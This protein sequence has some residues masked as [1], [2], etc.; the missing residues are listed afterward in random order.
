MTVLI[1]GNRGQLGWALERRASKAGISTCCVDLP[2]LDLTRAK[3]VQQMV[4]RE[5][6]SAVVN[7]AAYTAVDKAETDLE[8][9][10][11][12]NRD[13]VAHLA[14]ACRDEQIPLIHISTDYVFNGKGSQ[15]YKA[16]D[17]IDPLGVYGRSKAEGEKQLRK[18]MKQHLIIRTSWLYGV[19]GQNFVKTMLRLARERDEIRVVDD[20]KG[21]PT[22]AGDLADAI[23][24]I[25]AAMSDGM[26][27]AWGTYH[28][29]NAGVISWHHFAQKAIALASI[30]E[31]LMVEKIVPISTAEYPTPA[32]RPAYSA[33]D[34][35]S[36]TSAF[37]IQMQPWEESLTGMIEALYA[38]EQ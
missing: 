32:L 25:I 31:K 30:H 24:R 22:F 18:R 34:C 10:F 4:A 21:S 9:A 35:T 29:C 17:P 27:V 5:R 33:L 26:E 13:G 16:N 2:E 36:F 8:A 28:Y 19:H 12:V 20:Q 3:A 14:D 23:V 15:P 37:G 6:Y 1:I 7:A 38:V 11:A